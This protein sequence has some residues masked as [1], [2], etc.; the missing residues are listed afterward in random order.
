MPRLLP[1]ICL[2][3]VCLV[4]AAP[5]RAATIGQLAPGTPASGICGFDNRDIVQTTVISGNSYVVPP[6]GARIVSW[7]TNASTASGNTLLY[8]LKVFRKLGTGSYRV[9]AHD[10]RGRWCPPP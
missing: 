2:S 10:G 6:F 3:A 8:T 4:A 7:S 5:A 9:V 1:A